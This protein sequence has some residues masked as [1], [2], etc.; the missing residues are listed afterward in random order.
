MNQEKIGKFICK[1][2]KEHKLTQEELAKRIGVT[3]KA[4]SKW[5]NGRC[6]PDLSLFESICSIFNITVNELLSGEK[7]DKNTYQEKSEKNLLK[8]LKKINKNKRIT[9]IMFIS[10]LFLLL[11]II[12]VKNIKLNIEYDPRIMKCKIENNELFFEIKGLS[13]LEAHH[14]LV[15]NK[16]EE[17]H[18]FTTK[19][20][21]EK[22]KQNHYEAWENI[23]NR[24]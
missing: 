23:F 16:E 12:F 17:I 21:L 5:E 22:E 6:L 15:E 14:V 19:M 13:S 8:M 2:R 10:F 20:L 11:I 9:I 7:I 4:V 18:F 1:L 3:D 24:W